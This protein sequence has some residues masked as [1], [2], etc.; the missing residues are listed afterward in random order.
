MQWKSMKPVIFNS[1]FTR[2]FYKGIYLPVIL[3]SQVLYT[4][5]IYDILNTFMMPISVTG[6]RSR[7]I[8]HIAGDSTSS[9]HD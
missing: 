2:R 7:T 9:L 8:A 4:G 5:N 6:F 3:T 1:V